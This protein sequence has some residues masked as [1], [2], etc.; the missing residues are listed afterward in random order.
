MT[1][2][3]TYTNEPGSS[4]QRHA[5][6]NKPVSSTTYLYLFYNTHS[7]PR[8]RQAATKIGGSRSAPTPY[9]TQAPVRYI[10]TRRDTKTASRNAR[11]CVRS[12][13]SARAS[14]FIP[15]TTNT[16]GAAATARRAA[17][18]KRGSGP[19]P[20]D[21]FQPQLTLCSPRRPLSQQRRRWRVSNHIDPTP[22]R[23][24]Q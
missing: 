20:C 24:H 2:I 8:G 23:V 19:R 11:S 3:H 1:Y 4:Q 5:T 13:P 6:I 14:L 17:K 16:C 7:Q 21:S 22:N 12:R 15:A 10:W 9:A 18:S